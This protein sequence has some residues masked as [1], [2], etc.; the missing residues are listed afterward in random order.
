MIAAVLVALL[1]IGAALFWVG[2]YVRDETDYPGR[3]RQ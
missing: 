3:H 1:L 2:T